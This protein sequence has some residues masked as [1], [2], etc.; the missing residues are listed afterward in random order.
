M[1][2]IPLNWA[3]TIAFPSRMRSFGPS[4]VWPFT[5]VCVNLIVSRPTSFACCISAWANIGS[6]VRAL[7]SAAPMNM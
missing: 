4:A 5:Q 2:R 7:S 6:A 3:A 1:T